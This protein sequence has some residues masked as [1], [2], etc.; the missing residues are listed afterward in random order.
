L[1]RPKLEE[2]QRTERPHVLV[3][4]DDD[5]LGAFLADGLPLGGFWTSIIASGLQ[6]LEVFNLRQFDLIV[7][8]GGLQTFGAME[9]LR[10]LRGK[11][12]RDRSDRCRSNAPVVVIGDEAKRPAN[13]SRK[14]LG[15]A[16]YLAP[17][18]ELDQIVRQLHLVF[19]EWRSSHPDTRLADEAV[20]R[21]F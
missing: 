21:D 18:L 3:V 17:P 2:R 19:N 11:S 10:R 7:V 20:L 4:T 5:S 8:D 14:E 15:I 12:S 13:F 16:A 9:F 1:I 6:A